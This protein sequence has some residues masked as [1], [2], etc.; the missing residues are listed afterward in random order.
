MF[1]PSGEAVAL[2]DSLSFLFYFQLFVNKR[3][4]KRPAREGA[5]G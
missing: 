4:K 2:F 1:F 5:A 3:N